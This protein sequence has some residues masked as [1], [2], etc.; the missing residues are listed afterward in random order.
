MKLLTFGRGLTESV[1]NSISHLKGTSVVLIPQ[2]SD[3]PNDPL[4]W[5]TWRKYIS[6]IS[7]CAFAFLTNVSIGGLS[8]AFFP[9]SIEFQKSINTTSGLLTWAILVLGLGVS[10]FLSQHHRP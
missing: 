4:S 7:V 10:G 9:L 5:P 3:D 1:H 6:F 8:P 2:P